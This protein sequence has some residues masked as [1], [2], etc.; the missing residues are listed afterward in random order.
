VIPFFAIV[1]L[2]YSISVLTLAFGWAKL[3]DQEKKKATISVRTISVVIAVRNESAHLPFLIQDI[4]Q[5]SY[6]EGHF[7]IILV[8]DHSQDGSFE[9]AKENVKISNSIVIKLEGKD[10]GKKA[11]LRLGIAQASGE[12]IVTTDADCRL[13]PQWLSRI[14]ERFQNKE[15]KLLTGLV[16]IDPERSIFNRLQSLEFSSLIGAG[17]ATIGLG[18]PTMCNGANLAFLKSAFN[19]VNGYEG[20]ENIPSGDDEFLMRKINA[21][22]KNS[23]GFMLD[24][25]AIVSTSPAFSV[26]D[27]INQRLRWASKWKYNSSVFT[28]MTALTVLTFHLTFILF[29][30]FILMDGFSARQVAILWGSKMFVEAVFLMPV[31]SSLKLRWSWISFL[32]L[33]FTYSFYVVSVGI[34]S[35]IKSYEWKGRRWNQ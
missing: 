33:Q 25:D 27:W 11:A 3:N 13:L 6:P 26:T 8:D 34:L 18:K 32:L 28:R 35:Q 7:E 15:L 5:L 12:I 10:Q 4:E 20:N 24:Q 29:F 23:V 30:G 22:W 2:I 17:G 1:F 9:L 21:R 14:N 16:R 31:H 19:E